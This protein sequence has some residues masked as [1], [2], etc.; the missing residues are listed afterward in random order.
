MLSRLRPSLADDGSLAVVV[1]LMI[2][3]VLLSVA[4]VGR[5]QG[6]FQN[7]NYETRMEQ[8]RAQA[9]SGVSD[10]LFQIDQRNGAPSN[11]CNEPVP[12]ALAS[13]PCSPLNSIPS[14]PT[15][16][17]TVTYDAQNDAYTIYSRG[18]VHGVSYGLRAVVNANP[19]LNSALTGSTM[20]FDGSMFKSVIVTGPNGSP[21]AGAIPNVSVASQGNLTCNGSP[22]G[23]VNYIEYAQ[24]T[25]NCAPVQVNSNTYQPQP[26]W[27]QCPPPRNPWVSPPTPCLPGTAKSCPEMSSPGA[28]SGNNNN[29]WTI[30][31]PAT[32][33]PGV[34]VCYGGLTTTGTINVDYSQSRPPNNGRVQIYVFGPQTNPKSS[35]NMTFGGVVNPCEVGT[36]TPGSPATN[37]VAGLQQI[38]GDPSDLQVYAYGGGSIDVSGLTSMNAVLWAPGMAIDTHG[39]AVNITWTGAIV[40]GNVLAHG[41]PAT[42]NL[43]YDER[44]ATEFQVK[45][46]TISSYLQTQP[47]FAIPN[48]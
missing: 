30:T 25:T 20:V 23:K 21:V 2:V 18:T 27:P 44:L 3:V 12:P 22:Q 39:A 45:A 37:C 41:S 31:G 34:Y 47:T 13:N 43:Q 17:Y 7:A 24:S 33:E 29:G 32:L 6:D 26:P 15:A 42:F 28:V 1:V 4:L 40:I 10:A 11:F 8:A 16:A 36:P 19:V 5:V 48:Y 9:Q 46:W 14:A 35:V 38:V